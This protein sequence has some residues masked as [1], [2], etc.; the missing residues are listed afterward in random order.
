MGVMIEGVYYAEDPGPDTTLNGAYERQKAT[1]RHWITRDGSSG[2][3]PETGRYHLY[4]AWNCPWAHR[5][6]L[7]ISLKGL[8]ETIS[9]SYARPR[10]TPEGWVYDE[11]GPYADPFK[12]VTAL[13]QAYAL[14]SPAYTGRITVPLLWDRETDQPVSNE[15]ADIVRMLNDAFPGPDLA[16]EALRSEIDAWNAQI[17]A[18]VNNGVYRAGFA[19]TQ[20]AYDT[21]VL[22]LFATLD[23]IEAHL[24]HHRWLCGNRFTEADLRLFPTLARFDVAYHYAFKCNIRRLMD[25]PHLW[26]YAR[27]MY[28]MPGVAETVKFDIYKQG[29]F[30]PSELRNPLGIVPAGPAIDWTLPHGR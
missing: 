21:A 26:A 2:F 19:R 30:S 6:L 13:H 24:G 8:S 25:Y 23:E 29:Y 10:R 14:A 20:E 28:Q 16:P 12:G 9:V 5:A 15:S 18:E 17:Y 1:I 7:T 11:A 4:A 27:E 22:R 3:G